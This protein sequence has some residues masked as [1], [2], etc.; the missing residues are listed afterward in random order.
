MLYARAAKGDMGTIKRIPAARPVVYNS[1]PWTAF[2]TPA[3]RADN[4]YAVL[5]RYADA[6]RPGNCYTALYGVQPGPHNR[7]VRRFHAM[8]RR[9]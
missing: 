4:E 5:T 1:H 8:E 7:H 2:N 9:V 3:Q 6:P